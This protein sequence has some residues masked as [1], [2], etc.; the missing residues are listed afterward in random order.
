MAVAD[1]AALPYHEPGIVTILI[2]ISFILL[3]NLANHVLDKILYCGLLAQLFLGIGWGTPG[4][5]WLGR[6]FENVAVNLGYIGLLLVVY[7]GGLM[8]S[9]KDLRENILLSVGV[10]ITGIAL[11]ISASY[12]LLTLVGATPLQAFAAGAALCSTSLGTTFT[13]MNTSGLMA[14]KMGIVLTSAAMMD[15]VVGLVMVQVISNLGGASSSF[16]AVT[17]VRPI[18]VSIGFVAAVPLAARFIVQP[19]TICLNNKRATNPTGYINYLLNR[20]ATALILHSAILVGLIT[21]TSYAGTSNLFAAYLA[22]ASICWWDTSVTHS[23]SSQTRRSL[24]T[25]GADP[26]PSVTQSSTTGMEIFKRFFNQPLQRVLKPFFF[27]SIGFSV[28]I[29]RMFTGDVVWRG[30]VYTIFM[31]IGK[32]ACGFWLMRLPGVASYIPGL[33]RSSKMSQKTEGK[34]METAAAATRSAVVADS[35]QTPLGGLSTHESSVTPEKKQAAPP[36]SNE[37]RARTKLTVSSSLKPISLYPGCIVGCA[38]VARGEIGFL[39]S[40]LAESNGIFGNEPNG[41]IFLVVTWAIMLCTIIGPL[42]VGTLVGRV[43]QL[44]S[45]AAGGPGRGRVLGEWGVGSVGCVH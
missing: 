23:T 17:I 16:S 37:G 6:E 34:K 28:P 13:V 38:M 18:C 19:L 3:L 40:S 44:E 14:T 26:T 24:S 15:D 31:F 21:A 29:T 36:Q 8:T 39:I 42:I 1:Q 11:P 10:A 7:E 12:I 30:I 45:R 41:P 2:L 32:F 33:G 9:F 5:N 43:K 27:A 20:D 35:Q 22:G 25:D 4:A